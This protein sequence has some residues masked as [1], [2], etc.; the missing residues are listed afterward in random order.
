MYTIY[1]HTGGK[2]ERATLAEDVDD[3]RIQAWVCSPDHEDRALFD[4]AGDLIFDT[5][6][7]AIV[8][9]VV[10]DVEMVAASEAWTRKE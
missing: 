3:E 5:I 4:E 1:S 7:D 8:A 2:H 6:E 9:C 10:E